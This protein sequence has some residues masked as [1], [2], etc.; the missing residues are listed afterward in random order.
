MDWVQGT[1]NFYLIYRDIKP[2]EEKLRSANEIVTTLSA[3]LA[4]K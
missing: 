3:T 4:I 2:K 1:Y